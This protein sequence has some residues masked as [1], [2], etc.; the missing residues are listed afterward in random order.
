MFI[1][2]WTKDKV[3]FPNYIL[4]F[5]NG[6]K[7][8]TV[9]LHRNTEVILF[10]TWPLSLIHFLLCFSRWLWWFLDLWNSW[11]LDKCHFVNRWWLLERTARNFTGRKMGHYGSAYSDMHITTQKFKL[12]IKIS[13][14]I[15]C[16]EIAKVWTATLAYSV[17]LLLSVPTSA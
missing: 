13:V 5:F 17:S 14:P 9:M 7:H 2:I 16:R 10:C 11:M 4:S 15:F 1:W 3:L 6:T 8:K 12:L